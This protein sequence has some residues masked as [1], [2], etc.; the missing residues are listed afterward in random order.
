MSDKKKAEK[1]EAPKKEAAK[2]EAPK[3][4]EAKA[5]GKQ[6]VRVIFD[7]GGKAD[8]QAIAD[9][10]NGAGFEAETHRVSAVVPYDRHENAVYAPAGYDG[11]K[12]LGVLHDVRSTF[13]IIE[14]N[15][16]DPKVYVWCI[17]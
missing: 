3:K 9:K 16:G 5:S 2:K 17:K 11:K 1:K 7:R 4:E 14:A 12:L 6:A 8:A 10:L 13:E 15:D